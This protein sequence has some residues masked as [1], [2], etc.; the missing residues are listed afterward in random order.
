M[1]LETASEE[2]V[3]ERAQ[4]RGAEVHRKETALTERLGVAPLERAAALDQGA[5]RAV[6]GDGTADATRARRQA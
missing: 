4:G 6:R 5:A 3:S 1:G 2:L